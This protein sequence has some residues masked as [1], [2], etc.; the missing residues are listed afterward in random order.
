MWN[1][2]PSG[3]IDFWNPRQ[4]SKH[5]GGH[6]PKLTDKQRRRNRRREARK[7]WPSEDVI[8]KL[9]QKYV[10]KAHR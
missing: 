5:A 10:P 4:V 9:L 7:A 8:E 6:Q 1:D 3:P 2:P